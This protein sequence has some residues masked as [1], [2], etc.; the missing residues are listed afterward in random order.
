MKITR[1]IFSCL[2]TSFVLIYYSTFSVSASCCH[3]NFLLVRDECNHK[4]RAEL[5]PTLPEMMRKR[6]TT[7]VAIPADI[8]H[9]RHV[10]PTENMTRPH[11]LEKYE[12]TMQ[13]R[14]KE[15]RYFSRSEALANWL[16]RSRDSWGMVSTHTALLAF[17]AK[18]NAVLRSKTNRAFSCF[19]PAVTFCG[20]ALLVYVRLLSVVIKSKNN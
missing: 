5:A 2:E 11:V 6:T 12:G 17:R 19:S 3:I 9:S 20:V 14:R 18:N 16:R 13:R 15:E 7:L 8:S 4:G 1:Q 10:S